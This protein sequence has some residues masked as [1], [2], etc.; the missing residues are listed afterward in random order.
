MIKNNI[1]I[2]STNIKLLFSYDDIINLHI[3]MN[4]EIFTTTGKNSIYFKIINNL[5]EITDDIYIL[6]VLN[7]ISNTINT[8]PLLIIEIYNLIPTILD[9][10]INKIILQ[11]RI[12]CDPEYIIDKYK[13]KCI[14][15][16]FINSQTKIKYIEKKMYYNK[17]I[18]S[19]NIED[20][21]K[22]IFSIETLTNKK[23][24]LK[25]IN[26]LFHNKYDNL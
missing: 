4:K 10:I 12:I 19:L 8:S 16:T 9:S 2:N 26:K 15:Y 23:L 13:I 5:I 3:F 20:N 24:F 21:L 25:V 7:I 18:N 1:V 11:F 6:L 22:R 17:K 14:F